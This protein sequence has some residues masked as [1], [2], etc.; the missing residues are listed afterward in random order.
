MLLGSLQDRKLEAADKRGYSRGGE[1]VT[2]E[3]YLGLVRLLLFLPW[4][5]S[6]ICNLAMER[7]ACD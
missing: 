2:R 3:L 5:A 1:A 4:R 6:L 7:G